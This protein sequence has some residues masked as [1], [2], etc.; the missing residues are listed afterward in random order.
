MVHH[1]PI[2]RKHPKDFNL[3]YIYNILVFIIFFDVNETKVKM[4]ELF[5]SYFLYRRLHLNDKCFL[6]IIKFYFIFNFLSCC[7][8]L[9]IY[10]YILVFLI[11]F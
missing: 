7:I 9:Y 10:I 8:I 6:Y 5:I 2:Y 3:K 1:V 11:Y 4:R